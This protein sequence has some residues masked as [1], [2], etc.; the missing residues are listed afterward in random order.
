M[1]QKAAAEG[2]KISHFGIVG[3]LNMRPT[4]KERYRL[5]FHDWE[6]GDAVEGPRAINVISVGMTKFH[7]GHL[8]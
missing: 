1:Q 2:M 6:E 7:R 3:D 4:K 5:G 8:G